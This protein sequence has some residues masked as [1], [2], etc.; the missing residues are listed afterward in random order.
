M[1]DLARVAFTL[2]FLGNVAYNRGDWKH[3]SELLG[4]AL[5]I[6]RAL[7]F[8]WFFAYPLLW[9][10][11]VY[12]GQG[13]WEEATQLLQQGITFSERGRDLQALRVGNRVAGILDIL[14]GHPDRVVTQLE[15]L[16]DRPGLEEEDVT[17]FLSVLAWAYLELHEEARAEDIAKTA[18]ERS[19]SQSDTPIL[20]DAL[21]VQA[22]VQSRQGRPRE[23]EAALDEA[24]E[25]A[26][27]LPYPYSLARAL[28]D[29]GTLHVQMREQEAARPAF[30]EA[31]SIF[32]RLGAHRDAEQTE[33]MLTALA[34]E[35]VTNPAP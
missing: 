29:W 33:Q 21:V 32:R 14:T 26:R 13:R 18:V 12:F 30:D 2:G 17:L 1:G 3:A 25:L 23:A 8:S 24:I 7:G 6:N 16:L 27:R 34:S 35:G 22:L 11:E 20:I 19:R 28:R 31:L 4:R 5:S 10:G 15:P 9:M